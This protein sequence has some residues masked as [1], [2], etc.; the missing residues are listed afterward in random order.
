[1]KK[2][3]PFTSQV[4]CN[5]GTAHSCE[6]IYSC[7]S[8][9]W[10]ARLLD[11]L[12]GN[13]FFS[14]ARMTWQYRNL[15]FGLWIQQKGPVKQTRSIFISLLQMVES[16]L[17]FL[18]VKKENKE[19]T[20]AELK[21]KADGATFVYPMSPF[22]SFVKRTSTAGTEQMDIS[23]AKKGKGVERVREGNAEPMMG[24]WNTPLIGNA[25][26]QS[27]LAGFLCHCLSST[28]CRCIS[29][30]TTLLTTLEIAKGA[31]MQLNI[32]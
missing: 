13:Q 18:S 31:S 24:V 30:C 28:K 3:L 4:H 10:S 20:C 32:F 1:M 15:C 6:T 21:E 11:F 26:C 2:P 5:F 27:A 14:N 19:N 22:N 16:L 8:S 25:V 9:I 7:A 23:I 12:S 29:T 17:E